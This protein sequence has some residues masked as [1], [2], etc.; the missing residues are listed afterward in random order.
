MENY[1]NCRSYAIAGAAQDLAESFGFV[2]TNG[3]VFHKDNSRG[4]AI[5]SIEN[6][7]LQ[8][9]IIT[10]GRDE[11]ETVSVVASFTG[12][13]FQI[14]I[15]AQSILQLDDRYINMLPDTAW[16]FHNETK[17]LETDGW[18]QGAFSDYGKGRIVVFGEAAM[19]SAQLAGKEKRKMGMNNPVASENHQLLLNIIHWLDGIIE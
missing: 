19:F 9:N 15:K 18:S 16:V 1:S 2:F 10:K 3:F 7:G 8:Q 5:F 17:R 12:Q 4:P 6:K 13:A 14:P 11:N